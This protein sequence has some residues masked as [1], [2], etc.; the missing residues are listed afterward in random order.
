MAFALYE[1]GRRG[2]PRDLA[3][4][5][6]NNCR[7]MPSLARRIQPLC[8]DLKSWGLNSCM[9]YHPTDAC[10]GRSIFHRTLGPSALTCFRRPV[11]TKVGLFVS[12]LDLNLVMFFL[13]VSGLFR[14]SISTGS[15]RFNT[16]SLVYSL[17][18]SYG[19]C[20][21]CAVRRTP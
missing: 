14:Q 18:Y 2:T 15:T 3:Q 12:Y 9:L 11:E 20:V 13:L 7:G 8:T 1:I 10:E 4:G 16:G 21:I 17:S 19:I 6:T 5:L